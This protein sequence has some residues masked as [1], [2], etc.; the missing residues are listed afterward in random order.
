M[1]HNIQ[2]YVLTVVTF[3]T[4]VQENSQFLRVEMWLNLFTAITGNFKRTAKGKAI[5]V[6]D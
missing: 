2:A 1:M 5:P 3:Y 6:Q 4:R